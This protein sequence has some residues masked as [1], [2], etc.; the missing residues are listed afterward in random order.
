MKAWEQAA[1][2]ENPLS[3]NNLGVMYLNG[4]G[5]DKNETRAAEF[6]ARSAALG[7]AYGITSLAACY[8][9]G[10][11]LPANRSKVPSSRTLPRCMPLPSR[12]PVLSPEGGE[13][14]RALGAW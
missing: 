9:Y 2:Q 4:V 10:Q 7:N 12:T 3:L 6:F 8:I 11:G 1:E 5:V 14:S 13:R